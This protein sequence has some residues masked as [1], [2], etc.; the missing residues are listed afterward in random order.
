[1]AGA[2]REKS[3]RGSGWPPIKG[4]V[5][6]RIRKRRAFP[7]KTGGRSGGRILSR[8]NIPAHVVSRWTWVGQRCPY[9][10]P[11]GCGGAR[12]SGAWGRA[13]QHGSPRVRGSPLDH[14]RAL[15]G[16]RSIPAGAG[17]PPTCGARGWWR[18]VYPRGCGG[19]AGQQRDVA[20]AGFG[21]DRR[22]SDRGI[23]SIP[24][25]AGEPRS[26]AGA[27]P[28]AGVYP[29]GCGGTKSQID[30]PEK[31][32][33]LSPR[34]RGN[35]TPPDERRVGVGSIPAGAGEPRQNPPPW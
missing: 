16:H 34:V 31:Q 22:R 35:L 1:M 6:I 27:V 11:R 3:P 5:R 20:G 4:I 12:P 17:E 10:G 2:G 14:G 21:G 32:P 28:D 29:R 33:G 26:R 15:T 25:G 18:G 7:R 13:I 8:E 9:M 24:A 23:G 30:G 19:T